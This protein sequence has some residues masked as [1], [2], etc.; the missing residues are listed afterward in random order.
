ME[1]KALAKEFGLPDNT[2][3]RRWIKNYRGS[4]GLGDHRGKS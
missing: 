3:K 2:Y 1:Y 4:G